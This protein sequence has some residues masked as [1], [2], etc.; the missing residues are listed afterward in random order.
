MS[1]EKFTETHFVN[2]GLAPVADGLSGTV[3]SDWVSTALYAR[4]CFIVTRGVAT[5]GTADHTFTVRAASDNAGT[6]A[7]AIEFKYREGDL[8]SV[9]GDLTD[10]TTA[11]YLNTA[12]SNRVD[13]LEVDAASTPDEKPF[14]SLRSVENTD[15][16]VVTSIHAI[17]FMP[18]YEEATMPDPT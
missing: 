16:P 7:E 18:S 4:V 15:D 12:G 10:A 2:V 11:G 1:R 8:A 9:L 17:L 3:D 14:V 13:V 6:G 5:G